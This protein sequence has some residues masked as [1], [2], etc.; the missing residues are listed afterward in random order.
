MRIKLTNGNEA[1]ISEAEAE[2]I[3][4]EVSKLHGAIESNEAFTT[5]ALD[6][7]E[8]MTGFRPKSEAELKELL[9]RSIPG[10][11]RRDIELLYESMEVIAGWRAMKTQ[12]M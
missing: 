5:R 8:H 2:R 3:A 7:I 10:P 12:T 9:Y 4:G 11:T 1:E 6:N